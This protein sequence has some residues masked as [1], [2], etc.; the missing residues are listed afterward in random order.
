MG[1]I[2]KELELP[3]LAY[4]E[5]YTNIVWEDYEIQL[6]FNPPEII[7]TEWIVFRLNGKLWIRHGYAW[8]GASG[9]TIDTK[10]TVIAS[11]VHDALYQLMRMNL[12]DHSYRSV[13]DD[14]LEQAAMA[15][16]PWYRKPIAK[17]RFT[18]WKKGVNVF[19]E[20][21]SLPSGENPVL[22]AP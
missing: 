2:S 20:G 22:Y 4:K 10:N 13:V 18:L 16:T 8:D 21:S 1:N 17:I 11:L 19:G 14:L 12:L 3:T 15:A 6:P 7:E 9:P 5:G